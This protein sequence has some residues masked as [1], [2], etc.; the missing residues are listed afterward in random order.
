MTRKAF[1]FKK[2]F[3]EIDIAGNTYQVDFSDEKIATYHKSFEHF[4]K[5]SQR[6]KAIDTK[7]MAPEK[8]RELFEEMQDLVKSVVEELLGKGTY[9][10]LYKA[11][12]N[13]LINILELV[14]Y[15]GEIIEEKTKD[16]NQVN[17]KKYIVNKKSK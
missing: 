9:A 8:Q 17:K 13:S 14:T 6:I 3:E 5:E 10:D 11:S 7:D 12:G 16:I 1:E 2:S 15:L 4:Y